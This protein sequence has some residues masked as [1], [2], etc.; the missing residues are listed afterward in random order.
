[1]ST[2]TIDEHVNKVRYSLAVTIVDQLF[3]I[4]LSAKARISLFFRKTLSCCCPVSKSNYVGTFPVYAN[5]ILYKLT[6]GD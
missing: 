6:R 5:G 2:L 4:C 1:M 3:K